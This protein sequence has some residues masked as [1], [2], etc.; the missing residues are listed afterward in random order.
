[1]VNR[2]RGGSRSVEVLRDLRESPDLARAR[3]VSI[4]VGAND[5]WR[6]YVPW[7]D[8][9]PVDPDDFGR[10]LRR[11]VTICREASATE[12]F[13]SSPCTLHADPDHPWNRE[14]ETYRDVMR[15]VASRESVRYV[16]MGEE[17]VE[18]QRRHPE[19]KWTYDGVHP[20]PVGHE[21][22]ALTWL[23]W[24]LGLPA[25]PVEEIPPRPRAHRLGHW[26]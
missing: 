13:L 6:R 19:V 26:P 8:H 3:R 16:P 24:A 5:L 17:F 1:M 23:A 15:S 9:E 10:N 14:L 2:A 22:L 21:R 4:L 11:L 20:R 18:A 25:C 7:E 12:V